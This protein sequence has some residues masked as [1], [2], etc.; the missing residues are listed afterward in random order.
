MGTDKPLLTYC[1]RTFLETIVLNLRAAGLDR[2]AVV[3]GHHAE[4][5]QRAVNLE[6]VDVIINRDYQRGQTSSLQAGLKVLASPELEGIVLCL[7]DHPAVSTRVVKQLIARFQE[8]R[9]SAVIPT[10]E[11]RRGH[12]ALIGRSLFK[13]LLELSPKEGANSIFR[14]YRDATQ[15]VE[16]E[17]RGILLDVDDTESYRRLQAGKI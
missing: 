12:P 15:F 4:E 11:G 7:V 13:E 17:E 10:F 16:V 9:A 1:G 2:V 8:S 6:G 14:K 3:L 5:I